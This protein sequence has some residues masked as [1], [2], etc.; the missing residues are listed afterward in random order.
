MY[1][2][3]APSTAEADHRTLDQL[4]SYGN[5]LEAYNDRLFRSLDRWQGTGS[6]RPTD[7]TSVAPQLVGY[8]PQMDRIYKELDRLAEAVER[9][10]GIM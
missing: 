9:L 7:T 1:P 6:G 8:A 10:E 4:A 3:A 5:R 2:E